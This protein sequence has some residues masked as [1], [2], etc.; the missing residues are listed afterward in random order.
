MR[1][2]ISVMDGCVSDWHKLSFWI[3]MSE[4]WFIVGFGLNFDLEHDNFRGV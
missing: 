2:I 1:F 4:Q 3:R